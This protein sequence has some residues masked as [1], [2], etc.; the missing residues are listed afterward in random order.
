MISVNIPVT[1]CL[2]VQFMMCVFHFVQ[3][4]FR[5]KNL[6]EIFNILKRKIYF[7]TNKQTEQHITANNLEAGCNEFV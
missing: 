1:T 3:I 5:A 6:K 2:Q 7:K 4:T